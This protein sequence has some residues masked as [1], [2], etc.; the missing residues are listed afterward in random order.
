MPLT[1]RAEATEAGLCA[2]AV[3]A[4]N[5][6]ERIGPCLRALA[7]CEAAPR[8]HVT[9]LLNG[10]TDGSAAV[11]ERVM[12]KEGLAGAIYDIAYGD[13][14]HAMN[15]FLH[16]LRPSAAHYAMIDGYA[17]VE[18]P[19]LDRLAAALRRR[20][21][22][23]AA[24]A[25]PRTGRSAVALRQQMLDYPGLH[26]S[27][28]MLRGEFV[29]RLVAAGIRLPRNLYRGDG[30]IGSL[31]MHDL[32]ALG[33]GWVT[34]RVVVEGE[35]SWTVPPAAP[36]RCR[37]VRRVA[38]RMLQQGRGRLQTAALR[39]L[40][41]AGGFPSLPEDADRMVLDWIA[42]DPEAR[43]PALQRDPFARLAL[44]LMRQARPE[45]LPSELEPRLLAARPR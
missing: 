37:D 7:R 35:A 28:F 20:P 40:I 16:Q 15:L 33:G 41:Y 12:E 11:A 14:S 17:E 34:E 4:R 42:A 2:V 36:W 18:P 29:E 27:L 43:T 23:L 13:K 39:E 24:A 8:L 22:A 32:D 30:L 44:A 38:R 5:E 31:V 1:R 10:T 45:P 9:L 25:V 26:G 6:A 21:D 19:A 3:F